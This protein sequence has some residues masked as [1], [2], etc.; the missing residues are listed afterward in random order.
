MNLLKNLVI[1][2]QNSVIN[3]CYL[4]CIRTN[5][6]FGKNPIPEIWV[7]MLPANQIAEFLNELYLY[8]KLRKCQIFCMFME[9]KS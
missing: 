2:F 1:F 6:I 9:T 8:S 5:T 4:L 3:V 7:K